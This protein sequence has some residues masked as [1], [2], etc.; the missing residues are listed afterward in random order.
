M[1]IGVR[2]SL[3]RPPLPA[4]RGS[5]APPPPPPPRRSYVVKPVSQDEEENAKPLGIAARIASLQLKQGSPSTGKST[6]PQLITPE[7]LSEKELEELTLPPAPSRKSFL[8]A[9]PQSKR[10]TWDE[11]ESR[12]SEFVPLLLPFL[13]GDYLQNQFDS[14]LLPQSLK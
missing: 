7:E 6:L 3:P 14:L 2:M 8:P 9:V 11:I 1:E 5:G 13:E 10:P 12:G 4:R